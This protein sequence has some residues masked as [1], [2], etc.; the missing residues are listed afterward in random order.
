MS[1]DATIEVTR[2]DEQGRYEIRVDGV[3]AGFTEFR[4][5][6][7]LRA[8]PHTEIAPEFGGRGLATRV[9]AAGLAD[10]RADGVQVLPYCPAVR[11]YIAKH[12]EELDLVPADRR[13]EFGL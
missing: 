5:Q 11:G 1:D 4:A 3:L 8:F 9:I 2:N 13:A 6:G 12:P 7:E 10:S